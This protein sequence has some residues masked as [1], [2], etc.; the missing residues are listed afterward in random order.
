M[1]GARREFDRSL[2]A[3]EA[4]VIE[5]LAMV[6]EGLPLAA[7]ALLGTDDESLVLAERERVI[8]ALYLEVEHLASREV[9]LQAPVA[10]DLRFLLSVLRVTPELE[11]SH[12]LV[13]QVADRVG[14][15]APGGGLTPPVRV[16]AARM[17]DLA[18]RMWRQAANAWYQRDR[19][20]AADLAERAQE[21]EEL[22]AVLAA[23]LA[24]GQETVPAAIEITLV[25]HCYQR[26]GAHAVNIARRAAYLAGPA[27]G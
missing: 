13:M 20:A 10:A 16:L 8:D 14:L 17:G 3:I 2:E 11:R 23:E 1:P 9:L 21:M 18:G 6:V 4:K 27:D 26:L 7:R 25:A 5:L 24:A 19:S 15:A 12:D 22:R